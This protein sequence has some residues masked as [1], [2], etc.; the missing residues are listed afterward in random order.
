MGLWKMYSHAHMYVQITWLGVAW[1]LELTGSDD[2]NSSANSLITNISG[3][4]L[5]NVTENAV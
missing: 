5:K 3:K 2:R 4:S 1:K